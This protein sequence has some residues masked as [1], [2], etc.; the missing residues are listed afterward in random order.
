[1]KTELFTNING[2]QAEVIMDG[3]ACGWHRTGG[4]WVR[5]TTD[6][7]FAVINSRGNRLIKVFT[8]RLHA[9][10]YNFA[11]HGDSLES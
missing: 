3:M 8:D 11:I 4:T 9:R 2:E 10:R 7:K 5:E 6:G 1:M